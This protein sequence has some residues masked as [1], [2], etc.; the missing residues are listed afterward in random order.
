[1]RSEQQSNTT[2]TT[3]YYSDYYY[4]YHYNNYYYCYFTCPVSPTRTSH[5]AVLT[6]AAATL[7]KCSLK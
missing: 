7:D 1:M 4:H 5:V 2:P 3:D 6:H